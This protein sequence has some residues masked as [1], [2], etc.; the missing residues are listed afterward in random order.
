MNQIDEQIEQHKRDI[1]VLQNS[2]RNDTESSLK[3]LWNIIYR[4]NHTNLELP[5]IK[6]EI[7]ELKTQVTNLEQEICGLKTGHKFEYKGDLVWIMR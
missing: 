6:S 2:F 1:F 5:K 4:H 3:A 7:R